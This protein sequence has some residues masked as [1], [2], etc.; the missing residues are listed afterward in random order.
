MRIIDE[1]HNLRKCLFPC[2]ITNGCASDIWGRH[3]IL[4]VHPLVGK[5]WFTE[6]SEPSCCVKDATSCWA[7]KHI[8]LVIKW[9]KCKIQI[10]RWTLGNDW[11]NW[12][13]GIFF[14]RSFDISLI[15]RPLRQSGWASPGAM[16]RCMCL[17]KGWWLRVVNFLG[18]PTLLS[19]GKWG[20]LLKWGIPKT[21]GLKSKID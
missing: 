10:A 14:L 16:R 15:S 18:H 6:P 2:Y 8:I 9:C 3:G 21:I 20:E 5:A 7:W 17:P 19:I 4:Q 1:I 11:R 12:K 13:R